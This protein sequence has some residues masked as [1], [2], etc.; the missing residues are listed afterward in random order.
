[1]WNR[2]LRRAGCVPPPVISVATTLTSSHSRP[3]VN[4]QVMSTVGDDRTG[5]DRTSTP[6]HNRP[7]AAGDGAIAD[8]QPQVP[9]A[10]FGEAAA[11]DAPPCDRSTWRR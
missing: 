6:S 7:L 10:P 5:P 9:S 11:Y 3:M 8:D 4:D 1:M 2:L